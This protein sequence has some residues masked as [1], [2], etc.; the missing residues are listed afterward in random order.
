MY[1]LGIANPNF[2]KIIILTRNHVSLPQGSILHGCGW[3]YDA[4][5]SFLKPSGESYLEL[6]PLQLCIYEFTH[7]ND[8]S[9]RN[10][11]V[12]LCT[13]LTD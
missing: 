4:Y 7:F 10:I 1:Y 13:L 5:E 8:M 12:C 11:G 3:L 2:G 9:T 6:L